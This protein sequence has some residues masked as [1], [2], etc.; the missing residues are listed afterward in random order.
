MSRRRPPSGVHGF[1]H[2]RYSRGKGGGNGTS[3]AIQGSGAAVLS[4]IGRNVPSRAALAQL[5]FGGGS[6]Y[7]VV[8]YS[9]KTHAPAFRRLSR[10]QALFTAIDTPTTLHAW[11]KGLD[12]TNATAPEHADTYSLTWLYRAVMLSECRAAGVK[13]LRV[14]PGDTVGLLRN[15]F[16]DQSDWLG[17]FATSGESIKKLLKRLAYDEPIELLTVDLCIL[18][19]LREWSATSIEKS[20]KKIQRQRGLRDRP[21]KPMHPATVLRAALGSYN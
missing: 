19:G 17:R 4:L 10:L 15:G 1:S 18:G 6:A 13:A 21:G 3:Q 5:H 14:S 8:P 2:W 12:M 16:P 20:L 9:S 11:V 7:S